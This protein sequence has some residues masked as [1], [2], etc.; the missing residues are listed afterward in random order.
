MLA[1]SGFL[2]SAD[3]SSLLLQEIL[4]RSLANATCPF[5]EEALTLWSQGHSVDPPGQGQGQG[6]II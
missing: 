2:A 5:V 6:I 3:G 4:H 1:T